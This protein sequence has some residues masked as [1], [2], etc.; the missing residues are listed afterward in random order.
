MD[1]LDTQITLVQARLTSAV[2]SG[3]PESSPQVRHDRLGR[4]AQLERMRRL[5]A[6]H[7][8]IRL[9]QSESHGG[10]YVHSAD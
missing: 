9:G 4:D 6:T 3:E 5:W 8:R 2:K 7:R 1:G 10:T